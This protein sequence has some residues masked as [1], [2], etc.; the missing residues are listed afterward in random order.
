[1]NWR[2]AQRC[3]RAPFVLRLPRR[4][5]DTPAQVERGRPLTFRQRQHL[6]CRCGLARAKH[7]NRARVVARQSD[8]LTAL[9][10]NVSPCRSSRNSAQVRL[11]FF[12]FAPLYHGG[13]C[14]VAGVRRE[15]GSIRRFNLLGPLS[16][17]AGDPTKYCVW[18]K[19][20]SGLWRGIGMLGAER[21]WVVHGADGL[22]E[23]TVDGKL[24]GA[25]YEG[26][27]KLLRSSPEQFGCSVHAGSSAG[28]TPRPM[29]K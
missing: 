1:L 26:P 27:S 28:A 4:F 15:L 5:V 8:V 7:G 12:M 17:P 24:C 29:Q 10:V 13:N 2:H 11:A 14:R 3:A 9:G 18:S 25:T 20:S 22:D 6:Y 21:A 19:P 23:M 16:N